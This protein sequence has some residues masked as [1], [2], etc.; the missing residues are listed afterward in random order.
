MA[1][2]KQT[3]AGERQTVSL[4]FWITP[5]EKAELEERAAAGGVRLSDF[6]RAALLGYRLNVKNP[7]TERAIS[8]LWAIGNN[9]NQL[10][11]RANTTE[12]IDPQELQNALRLWREFVERLHE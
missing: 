5:S 2:R 12:E 6:A 9:L 3:D 11:R 10:A 7:V 8:E 4:S 1:R